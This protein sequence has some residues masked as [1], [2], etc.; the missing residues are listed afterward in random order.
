MNRIICATHEQLEK[1]E[2]SRSR[3]G[4]SS[5]NFTFFHVFCLIRRRVGRSRFVSGVNWI[6]EASA[7]HGACM[8]DSIVVHFNWWVALGGWRERS[9]AHGTSRLTV[10]RRRRRV[11]LLQQ[12]TKLVQDVLGRRLRGLPEATPVHNYRDAQNP[13]IEKY[14][15]GKGYDILT[16]FIHHNGRQIHKKLNKQPN[17]MQYKQ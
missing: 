2:S 17:P 8:K 14:R 3:G 5:F 13:S 15:S 16:I 4:L 12:P 11:W 10:K 6:E 1:S 7:A 9:A